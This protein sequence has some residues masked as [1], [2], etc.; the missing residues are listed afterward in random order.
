MS[1]KSINFIKNN[2]IIKSSLVIFNNFSMTFSISSDICFRYNNINPI[3]CSI[4]IEGDNYSFY[5]VFQILP[6]A[7]HNPI[8]FDLIFID[9]TKEEE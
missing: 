2:S 3:H 9:F 7:N 4:N 5:S 8:L 6:I 1:S